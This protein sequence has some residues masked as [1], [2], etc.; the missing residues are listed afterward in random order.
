M[1]S[2]IVSSVAVISC[3][4]YLT[5]LAGGKKAATTGQLTPAH[6]L[7]EGDIPDRKSGA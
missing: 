7:G 3:A 6:L 4:L 5:G 1:K 2:R